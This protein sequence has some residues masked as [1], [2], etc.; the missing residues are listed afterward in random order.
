M[1]RV[2]DLIKKGLLGGGAVAPATYSISGTVYDADG[3]TPVSGATVALGA[4]NAISG[5]D[6]TYTISN[7]PAGTSG[8]MTC[9]KSGYLWASI[10]VS[11]MAGN[12]TNQNYTALL[13][14]T[15]SFD[16]IDG[17]LGN[18]WEYTAGKWT[19][20]GNAAAGTPGLGSNVSTNGTFASDT[21]W[22]KGS[23]WS[24]T[25]GVARKTAGAGSDL[26][27]SKMTVGVWYQI[28]F[29]IAVRTAGTFQAGYLDHYT[30][31]HSTVGSYADTGRA[32]SA[33]LQISASAD[34]AGDVDNVTSRPITVADM[35]ATRDFTTSNFDIS[36]PVTLSL[37]K[38]AGIVACLDSKTSP[39]NFLLA[40]IEYT[41]ARIR[42]FK[43]V[44]GTYTELIAVSITYSAGA[45]VRLV[46]S[47]NNVALYY[48]GVQKGTTQTVSDA[49]IVNNTR[50]GLFSTHSA[51][52][53]AS[54]T[55]NP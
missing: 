36:V 50:H 4:Y 28:D 3:S 39:A 46:K 20:A 22:V 31:P 21:S 11:A 34:A 44:A 52:Q 30:D 18:G 24:I 49:G 1:S 15:D 37:N 53:L 19:V 9:T 32:G 38:Q 13:P 27:Q 6:G 12:L 7:I 33:A 54:F 2:M 43:C 8:S 10:S 14:F 51:N 48:N 17:D 35:F 5:A 45:A 25:S 29:D 40:F 41:G 55:I 26:A 16:R 23:G 42:L 47:G